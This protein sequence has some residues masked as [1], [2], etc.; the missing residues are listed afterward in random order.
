MPEIIP[1][2]PTHKLT[3]GC[4]VCAKWITAELPEIAV[5]IAAVVSFSKC[6]TIWGIGVKLAES[7]C[8]H[9]LT[10]AESMNAYRIWEHLFCA[11]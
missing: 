7:L 1:T 10:P 9:R 8:V 6:F 5:A 3:T 4:Q 11:E 2:T